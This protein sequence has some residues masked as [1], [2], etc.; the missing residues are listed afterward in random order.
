MGAG[1]GGV[2]AEMKISK[3]AN[4][5]LP[6]VGDIAVVLVDVEEDVLCVP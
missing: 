1:A 6:A 4:K 3:E 5:I 2:E